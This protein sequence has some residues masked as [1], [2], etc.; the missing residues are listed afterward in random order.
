MEER[1][2][3][4]LHLSIQEAEASWVELPVQPAD[5]LMQL[6][7]QEVPQDV[8]KSEQQDRARLVSPEHGIQ[9]I[10]MLHVV[11]EQVLHNREQPGAPRPL[12]IYAGARVRLVP[13]RRGPTLQDR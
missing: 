5:H 7:I 1:N 2:L 6:I 8:N 12:P 4:H 10:R 9:S 3:V 13:I 11:Q